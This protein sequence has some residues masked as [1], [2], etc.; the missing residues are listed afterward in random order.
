MPTPALWSH[1]LPNAHKLHE[2]LNEPKLSGYAEEHESHE[3][4]AHA[5]EGLVFP[6]AGWPGSG[7]AS[8]AVLNVGFSG[9]VF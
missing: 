4:P 2:P 1:G 6:T 7:S 9:L 3:I 5:T 8:W